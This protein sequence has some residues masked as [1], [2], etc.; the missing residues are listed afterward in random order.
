MKP[1]CFL[2][3]W[4]FNPRSP[5]GERPDRKDT[6]FPSCNFNPRS[7]HGE[8]HEHPEN[9]QPRL[10]FNPRSPHGERRWHFA[11]FCGTMR[12]SIHAPRTG[13]DRPGGCRRAPPQEISI[14]APRT[15][16]DNASHIFSRWRVNIS[17][18]APRTGSDQWGTAPPPPPRYFNPRSPHGER[19]SGSAICFFTLF[20]FNPR[21]PHGERRTL[22]CNKSAARRISIHAPRTGSDIFQFSGGGAAIIS[23]HA[24]RT[25]SDPI[26]F[27]YPRPGGYF[28]PRSPHGERH[29]RAIFL[30]CFSRISIHAP[31]TGSDCHCWRLFF[32][33][34]I[35]IH[36]P[37][38]GSDQRI[39]RLQ[40]Q[41]LH[42]NPRSPHGER[43]KVVTRPTKCTRC[44][45]IHAPRTG[46]D[47]ARL[48]KRQYRRIS[49][50]A[51][52][53]GSDPS[54]NGLIWVQ[55]ISIHA[56]RT[57]SDTSPISSE[58]LTTYFNPRS[59]HG[60]RRCATI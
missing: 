20:H 16:S 17:I 3:R 55:G 51:P 38:T 40:R 13:S 60:E 14:H 52:R 53:T 22:R 23:I 29:A 50:H 6:H 32:R 47:F 5:H 21:S 26:P 30:S 31:R 8:R 24:P 19:L 46:S 35:S 49:I 58:K 9:Q 15:G 54:S 4:Y 37:R 27:C 10:Y 34:Q 59:P 2:S 44:I 56:P 1:F 11:A 45:S 42:F 7:P 36:A 41:R 33:K 12:I 18:H 43:R 25:G 28:N 57:G 39:R 48:P